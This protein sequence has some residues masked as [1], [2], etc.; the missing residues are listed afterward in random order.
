MFKT[1][2]GKTTQVQQ[3]TA[4]VSVRG[5]PRSQTLVSKSALSVRP[6][7]A[8]IS[9]TK[10]DR[11]TVLGNSKRKPGFP[12]Q[13]LPTDLRSEVPFRNFGC[14]QVGAWPTCNRIGELGSVNGTLLRSAVCMSFGW[15]CVWSHTWRSRRKTRAKIGTRSRIPPPGGLVSNS[16]LEHI[17]T[18]DQNIFTKFGVQVENRT[19]PF[20]DASFLYKFLVSVSLA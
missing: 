15:N 1:K 12:I 5:H 8:N 20:F 11:R 17:S 13:Y 7:H 18:T 2:Y 3:T 9:E 14:F 4:L 10:R 16:I 19:Q 6:S